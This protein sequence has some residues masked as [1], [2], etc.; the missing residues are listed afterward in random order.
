MYIYIHDSDFVINLVKD[1]FDLDFFREKDKNKV[2]AWSEAVGKGFLDKFQVGTFNSA[3]C[4]SGREE[5][6]QKV[7]TDI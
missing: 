3:Y 7:Y 2:R 1:W 6:T 4:L 5:H